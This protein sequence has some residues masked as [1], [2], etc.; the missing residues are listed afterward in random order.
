MRSG[1]CG[2]YLVSRK[3]CIV[4]C[5]CRRLMRDFQLT[6]RLPSATDGSFPLTSTNILV[7]RASY[8]I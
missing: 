4:S 3:S 6:L 7:S 5:D 1:K 8:P 2:T